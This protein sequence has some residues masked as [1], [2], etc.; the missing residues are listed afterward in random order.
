MTD[1]EKQLKAIVKLEDAI[2]EFKNEMNT[3]ISQ[4]STLSILFVKS[5]DGALAYLR[6]M[7]IGYTSKK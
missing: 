3:V 6:L 2:E 5:L 7:K 4:N 1:T